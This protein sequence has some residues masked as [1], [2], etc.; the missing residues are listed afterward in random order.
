MGI[1]EVAGHIYTNLDYL[2]ANVACIDT[3]DGLVLVDTPTLPE[4]ISHWKD[5]VDSLK[6]KKVEYII[7]F[8]NANSTQTATFDSD[9]PSTTFTAVYPDNATEIS[10]D[11][12]GQVTVEVPALNF[13]IYRADAPLPVSAGAPGILFSTLSNDQVCQPLY[14]S[15][16]GRHRHYAAAIATVEWPAYQS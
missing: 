15:S 8:N 13:V 6:P 4:E 7:A 2:P 14:T 9:T 1:Q 16:V 12:S 5:F 10:S 11:A 3:G